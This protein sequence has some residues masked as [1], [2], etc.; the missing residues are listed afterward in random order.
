MEPAKIVGKISLREM[1]LRPAGQVQKN[2]KQ[3]KWER[4]MVAWTYRV[5]A[6]RPLLKTKYEDA[7]EKAFA[8]VGKTTRKQRQKIRFQVAVDI[9][10]QY[11]NTRF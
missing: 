11:R 8:D 4:D 7:L 10:K 9:A 6:K 1:K 5:M 2:K 3:E